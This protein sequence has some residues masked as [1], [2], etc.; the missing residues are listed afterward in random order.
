MNYNSKPNSQGFSGLGIA[1]SLMEILAK[2]NFKIPTA[3]Q[4][5]AIPTALQ[6]KDL[7]GVAQ[8]GTGKTLAFGIP[9]I[10]RL[11]QVKGCG[12]VVLPTRELAIQVD[13]ALRQVGTRLGL[14]TAVLI[15]GTPIN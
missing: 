13:E 2:L 12:L 5:Q 4:R 1:P 14:K 8:T 11:N 3:I 15:G 7:V 10:Q 6:G 9:M